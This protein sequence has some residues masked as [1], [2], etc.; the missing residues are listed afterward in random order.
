MLKDAGVL[1][2]EQLDQ[3]IRWAREA[4]FVPEEAWTAPV[5]SRSVP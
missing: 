2:D 4:T 3:A 5:P 1:S